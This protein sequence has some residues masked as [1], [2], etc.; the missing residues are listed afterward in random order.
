MKMKYLMVLFQTWLLSNV[1]INCLVKTVKSQVTC[2][3]FTSLVLNLDMK[4][5]V[6]YIFV[7]GQLRALL[8]Q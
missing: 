6:E 4:F 2:N 1:M 5:K 3:F 8:F 7:E